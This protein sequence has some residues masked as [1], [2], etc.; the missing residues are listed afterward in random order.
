[1]L[2]QL[3]KLG[4]HWQIGFHTIVDPINK[5]VELA[6][7]EDLDNL[8]KRRMEIGMMPIQMYKEFMLK[9]L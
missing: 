3:I 1:M 6:D 5:I 7:T 2:T 4:Q 9:N 8:D